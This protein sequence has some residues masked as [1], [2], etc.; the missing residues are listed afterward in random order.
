[1][2]P[3]YVVAQLG[4]RMHY[5]VPRLL[6]KSGMLE[7]LYTDVYAVAA[8]RKLLTSFSAP[9]PFQRLRTRYAPGIADSS[10]CMFLAF[11]TRYAARLRF[12]RNDAE[13]SAAFLWAGRRFGELVC[14]KGFGNANAIYVYNDAG[15]E[16]LR[17]AKQ[18]GLRTVL[19]QT[20]APL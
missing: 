20:I 19:E 16:I 8:V 5:G 14:S 1:M 6:A 10:V 3:R 7:S 4:A 15:L 11:G 12:A 9:G 13:R 18:R 2:I 17:S